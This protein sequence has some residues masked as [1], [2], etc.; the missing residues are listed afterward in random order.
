M[1]KYQGISSSHW[2]EP[3][4]ETQT[5]QN[6]AAYIISA[7]DMAGVV[8]LHSAST[9]K[10]LRISKKKLFDTLDYFEQIGKLEFSTKRSH[11]VWKSA[12]WHSLYKGNFTENQLKSVQKLV[13]K[14]QFSGV[15]S[16]FFTSNLTVFNQNKYGLDLQLI[17]I[18]QP[19]GNGIIIP[20]IYQ[21]ESETEPETNIQSEELENVDQSIPQRKIVFDFLKKFGKNPEK[22]DIKLL[23]NGNDEYPGFETAG[24]L[25]FAIQSIKKPEDIKS[26]IGWLLRFSEN[27]GQ[28]LNDNDFDAYKRTR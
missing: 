8:G 19:N 16:Q 12:I 26:P 7:R 24:R 28:Y 9:A 27:P 22:G 21:S 18:Q 10:K 6:V 1:A 3:E 17:D 2:D 20:L 11:I 25:H 15:F 5:Q 4:Y 14:W 13:K 23:I